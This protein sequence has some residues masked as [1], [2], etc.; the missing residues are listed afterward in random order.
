VRALRKSRRQLLTAAHSSV[1]GSPL[2]AGAAMM[3]AGVA[4][5]APT[6]AYHGAPTWRSYNYYSVR[7]SPGGYSDIASLYFGYHMWRHHLPYLGYPFQYPVGTGLFAWLAALPGGGV[8]GYF[9]LSVL[10]LAICGLVAIWALGRLPGA[11]PWVLA[12]APALA[13]YVALNWDLL[14]LAA[15]AVALVLFERQRDGW[16]A[17]ALALATWTKLFPIVALPVVLCARALEARTPRARL[18]ATAAV[19]IPFALVSAAING[20]FALTTGAHGGLVLSRGWLFFFTFN[21]HRPLR[22]TNAWTL[23]LP[24]GLPLAELNRLIALTTL[25]G[26]ALALAALAWATSRGRRPQTLIIPATLACLVWFLLANKVYSP[27]YAVWAIALLA[28]AGA[29]L[30][31]AI[32]FAAAD[33]AF[34]FAVFTMDAQSGALRGWIFSHLVVPAN[35]AL[36]ALLLASFAWALAAMLRPR[37]GNLPA[38]AAAIFTEE[39]G[40]RRPQ[41][42]AAPTAA[43]RQ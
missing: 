1:S 35:A 36:E 9:G 6:F 26:L 31:L 30:A 24:G 11:R 28:A 3:A 25:A 12:L 5:R 16:G 43:P 20:P 18:R 34:F 27:Q 8:A 38:R 19:L 39:A 42:L 17:V 21:E 37:A 13:L 41:H 22:P 15:L 14:S 10:A 23:L 33:L 2:L 7:A 40:P 4:L 32:A 29:P